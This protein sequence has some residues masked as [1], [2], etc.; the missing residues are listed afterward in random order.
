MLGDDSELRYRL[1]RAESFSL[2]RLYSVAVGESGVDIFYRGD[3]GG[4]TFSS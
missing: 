1:D 3:L 2:Y 4:S